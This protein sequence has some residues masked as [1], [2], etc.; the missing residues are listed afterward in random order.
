MSGRP[1]GTSGGYDDV[2]ED[3]EA[4]HDFTPWRPGDKAEAAP[5]GPDRTDPFARFKWTEEQPAR[6][7]DG[8][9][10]RST[11]PV[12]GLFGGAV[13]AGSVG[14]VESSRLGLLGEAYVKVKFDN[15]YVEE[16]KSGDIKREG[17]FG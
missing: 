17:W 4:W 12:G 11:R 5:T 14:H 1:E 3:R 10:V 7:E 6:F 2:P 15:G 9:R 13:P 16:V 8:D